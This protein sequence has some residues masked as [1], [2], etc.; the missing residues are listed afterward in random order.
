MDTNQLYQLIPSM[1]MRCRSAPYSLFVV[2]RKNNQ[3]Q[4]C[5]CPR[6]WRLSRHR[7]DPIETPLKLPVRTSYQYRIQRFKGDPIVTQVCRPEV[8]FFQWVSNRGLFL[9]RHFCPNPLT[10]KP[11]YVILVY[12]LVWNVFCILF[13]LDVFC[14][15]VSLGCTN[16][17]PSL[18]S[19][20]NSIPG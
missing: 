17:Q 13:S 7:G 3:D 9:S 20:A 18:Q 8:F 14:M 15:L 2:T 4:T 12:N 10:A 1:P 6:H 16:L 19:M 5:S 11:L